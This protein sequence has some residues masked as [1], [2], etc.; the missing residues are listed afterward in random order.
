VGLA[1]SVAGLG[2]GL[3][4]LGVEVAAEVGT[5]GEPDLGGDL[6]VA[7]MAQARVGKQVVSAWSSEPPARGRGRW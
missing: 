1:E 2:G 6:A 3:A 4:V 5:R 7:P